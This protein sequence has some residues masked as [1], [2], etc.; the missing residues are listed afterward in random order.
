[1]APPQLPTRRLGEDGP[2]ITALGFGA[3]V[4]QEMYQSIEPGC[5][6]LIEPGSIRL[7]RSA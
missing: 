7:L 1:M 4:G 5:Q 3:M 6:T 2:Q